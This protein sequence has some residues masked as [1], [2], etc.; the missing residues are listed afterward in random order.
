MKKEKKNR[1]RRV[2]NHFAGQVLRY[3]C[4]SMLAAVCLS[5]ICLC[6]CGSKDSDIQL[7]TSPD[8]SREHLGEESEERG[9][10]TAATEE[11]AV[12][13]EQPQT[14]YVYV[15]GAVV[16]PG[17]YEMNAGARLY[18]VIESANG[19]TKE[20][21]ETS[22]NLAGEVYDGMMLI[23]PTKDQ[24]AGGEFVPD[25]NGLPVRAQDIREVAGKVSAAEGQDELVDINRAT[26]DQ[27]CTLPGVGKAKAESILAYRQEH[28][29]FQT[30]EEIKNVTGIGD[31][32]FE[33]IRSKIKV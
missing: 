31:G 3:R 25:E 17:V 33:K 30:I 20:A 1:I 24:W 4:K 11:C 23:I 21:E 18:D 5:A 14:C 2:K 27:L 12:S 19:M 16:T 28:G 9:A 22:F 6:G 7:E 29:S 13:E 15:C 10:E 8:V 26:A 32:L